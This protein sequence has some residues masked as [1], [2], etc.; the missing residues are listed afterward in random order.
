MA[1]PA[2]QVVR[3]T[4]TSPRGGLTCSDTLAIRKENTRVDHLKCRLVFAGV[5]GSL[6]K[7]RDL[8]VHSVKGRHFHY[9]T[10]E[11]S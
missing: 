3:D 2:Q 10:V 8:R 5:T 4:C 6:K 11:R 7:D 9:I 1:K